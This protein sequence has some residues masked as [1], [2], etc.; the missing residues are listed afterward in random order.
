MHNYAQ[1]G[2]TKKTVWSR[3]TRHLPRFAAMKKKAQIA[4]ED[5][6]SIH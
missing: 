2:K 1:K 6:C 5:R 3:K 4:S